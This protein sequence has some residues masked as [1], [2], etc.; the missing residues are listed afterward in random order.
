MNTAPLIHT[1]GIKRGGARAAAPTSRPGPSF[2]T[3]ERDDRLLHLWA[4]GVPSREIARDV[5]H[6]CNRNMVIGRAYRIGAGKH[7][8]KTRVIGQ[9]DWSE[10][11][12]ALL[13]EMRGRGLTFPAMAPF[14]PGRTAGALAGKYLR[15]MQEHEEAAALEESEI[16]SVEAPPIYRHT[17]GTCKRSDCNATR[18]PGRDLCAIHHT[19]KFVRDNARADHATGLVDTVSSLGDI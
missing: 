14:F 10:R 16:I 8:N 7:P 18:Q 2:W 5:G 6:G 19:E 17:T 1:K 9:R 15:T 4:A 3:M 12:T 13:V 11:A